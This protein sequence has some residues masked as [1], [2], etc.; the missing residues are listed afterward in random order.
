MH[1]GITKERAESLGIALLETAYSIDG[2]EVTEGNS[3]SR[4]E[5]L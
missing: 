5:V 3:I 2:M 4:E 1:S